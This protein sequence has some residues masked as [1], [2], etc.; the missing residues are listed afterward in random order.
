MCAAKGGTWKQTSGTAPAGFAGT[1]PTPGFGGACIAYGAQ[2]KGQD[3]AGTP[4]AFSAKGTDS[5]VVTDMGFCYASMNW[6]AVYPTASCPSLKATTA[7]F[8]ANAAYD[9]SVASSQCRYAKSIA[10]KLA[11]ALTKADG[12]TVA[13]GAYVDLST[14]TTMGDCIA[15]GGSWNNWVGKAA[16]TSAVG[17]DSNTYKK[18]NWDYKTQAP[19]ADEG[20]LHCHSTKTE[21]LFPAQCGGS[22]RQRVGPRAAR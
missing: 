9:W 12:S 15:N 5:S 1:F 7:P 6:T 17:S 21:A 22:D 16:T 4:K 14:Y 19:D 20:C 10:G 8:D 2:F 11:S 18:P 13:A 3:A